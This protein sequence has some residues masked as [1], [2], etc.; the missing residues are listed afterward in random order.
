MAILQCPRCD[1]RFNSSSELEWHLLE[2]HEG[3][4]VAPRSEE[5]RSASTRSPRAHGP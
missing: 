3:Q 1:L 4:I 2:D 5:S